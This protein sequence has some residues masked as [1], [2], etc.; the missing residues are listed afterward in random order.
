MSKRSSS[1]STSSL[2]E[3][4]AHQLAHPLISEKMV[5]VVAP[6]EE[7]TET[8][9]SKMKVGVVDLASFLKIRIR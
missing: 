1:K 6:F 7:T 4:I 2:E 8:D 5:N 3:K 9:D